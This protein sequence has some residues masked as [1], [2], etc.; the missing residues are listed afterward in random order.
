MEAKSFRSDVLD[1]NDPYVA[2]VARETSHADVHSWGEFVKRFH[3]ERLMIRRLLGQVPL[4]ALTIRSPKLK[5][6][7]WPPERARHRRFVSQILPHMQA[8]ENAWRN[9]VSHFESHIVPTGEYTEQRAEAIFVTTRA[10]M[11]LWATELAK[12]ALADD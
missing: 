11:D 5:R 1:F 7:D 6:A 10:M 2:R 8:I 3:P 9:K 4:G 12:P